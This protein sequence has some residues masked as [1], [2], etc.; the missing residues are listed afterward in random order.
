[1]LAMA[2]AIS[3]VATAHAQTKR[4]D[5]LFVSGQTAVGGDATS[6][7]GGAEWLHPTSDLETLDVG[8]FVGTSAGGWFTYGRLGGILAR[9]RATL[10]GALDLG[11]GKEGRVRFSY[12]RARTEVD[13]P[14][15]SPRALAQT[16]VDHIRVAGNIVT[17]FRFGG[18]FQVTPRFSTTISSHTYVSGGDASPAGSVRGDYA[19]GRWRV[20]G[21][22]FFSKRPSL[23]STAVD[24]SPTLHAT[25]TTFA[26]MQVRA[27][28]QE[29]VGVVDVSE[30]PRG[31]V[32]TVL[33]SVR[34]PLQ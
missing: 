23:S 24:L 10:S 22:M 15:G 16:E 2:I 9:P 17:G 26:G 30:Q 3:G 20:L 14:L 8:A 13:V 32:A 31:R 34:V 7:G 27:G 21:G 28:A 33:L 19:T 4:V 6:R 25:R 11:G 5:N 1:M 12:T 29:I 18:A